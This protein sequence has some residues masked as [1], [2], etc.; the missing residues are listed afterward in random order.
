MRLRHLYERQPSARN[1]SSLDPVVMAACGSEGGRSEKTP[2]TAGF[3]P[4]QLFQ[5]F[6]RR[7]KSR[8]RC[9]L[10]LLVWAQNILEIGD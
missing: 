8:A 3:G 10:H 1:G 5:L 9:E 6:S 2:Q 4:K 7:F